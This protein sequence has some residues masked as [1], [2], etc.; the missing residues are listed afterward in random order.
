MF[1]QRVI[2]SSNGVSCP[3]CRD[4]IELI[5]H[6]FVTYEISCVIYD[7]YVVEVTSDSA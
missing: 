6:L 4:L 2:V 7:L 1:K 3:F 5:S